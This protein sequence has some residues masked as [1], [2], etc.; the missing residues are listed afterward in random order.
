MNT[1]CGKSTLVL[2]FFFFV[3]KAF[4]HPPLL[5]NKYTNQNIDGWL[6][7][8]KLDGIRALWDGK[9]LTTRNGVA[10][11]APHW[12][13]L[14][15]PPFALDGELWSKRDDFEHIQSIVMKQ[16][17]H[18]DWKQ[19]TYNIF[20]VPRET[21]ELPERLAVLSRWTSQT[22]A[23]YLRQIPQIICRDKAHLLE[24]HRKIK[25]LGG[26]GVVLRDPH[27]PY[28]HGRTDSALKVKHFEDAECTVTHLHSGT[29]KYTSMLGSFSCLLP[30]GTTFRIGTGLSDEQRKNPPQPGDI[31]T[32]RHQGWTGGGKPRFPVFLR[33]RLLQPQH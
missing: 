7:S 18:K 24:F 31:V 2:I 17:P 25:D 4:A 32:F 3:A 1:P 8:E 16:S 6:M 5:L 29:G 23:P 26:E 21:G 33:I 9:Q 30:N 11:A 14:G 13:T 22:E 20:D 15:F 28:I 19:L 10:L 27:A 12:F